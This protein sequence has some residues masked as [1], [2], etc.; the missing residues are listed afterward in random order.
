VGEAYRETT[1][2]EFGVGVGEAERER[3]VWREKGGK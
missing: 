3:W 2:A 1:A